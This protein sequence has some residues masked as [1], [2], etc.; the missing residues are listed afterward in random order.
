M[1]QKE[2][3]RVI[4]NL[5]LEHLRDKPEELKAEVIRL[6]QLR[7]QE[8]E[9]KPPEPHPPEHLKLLPQPP[10]K[11][12][13]TR[14]EGERLAEIYNQCQLLR[15]SQTPPPKRNP[16][17]DHLWFRGQPKDIH[18]GTPQKLDTSAPP[19]LPKLATATHIP[20]PPSSPVPSTSLKETPAKLEEGNPDPQAT[21]SLNDGEGFQE[22]ASFHLAKRV[23]LTF[24]I[25]GAAA[26][27]VLPR[28]PFWVWLIGLFIAVVVLNGVVLREWVWKSWYPDA[29]QG[30]LFVPPDE[31]SKAEVRATLLFSFVQP[32]LAAVPLYFS[33]EWYHFL[34]AGGA[35][36]FMRASGSSAPGIDQARNT[37]LGVVVGFV[38]FL[39][40]A[41]FAVNIRANSL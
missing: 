13:L 10:K 8:S 25:I 23:M 1:G 18:P 14:Q 26:Y 22:G 20:P 39:V 29:D 34:L 15:Q 9:Q 24:V 19:A 17:Q 35:S 3:D 37:N 7:M 16:W 32:A 41:Y 36:Y 12:A 4:S 33:H 6:T 5:G 21:E 38:A 11:R 31:W 27:F 2:L 28:Y 40:A 30:S